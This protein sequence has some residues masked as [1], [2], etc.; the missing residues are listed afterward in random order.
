MPPGAALNRMTRRRVFKLETT[1]EPP[2]V[3]DRSFAIKQEAV[4]YAESIF[5]LHPDEDWRNTFSVIEVAEE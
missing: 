1:G 5:L 3:I 2:I 4:E